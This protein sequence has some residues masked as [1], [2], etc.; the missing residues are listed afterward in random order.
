MQHKLQI[1]NKHKEK[2]FFTAEQQQLAEKLIKLYQTHLFADWDPPGTNDNAKKRFLQRLS[3]TDKAYP[4]GLQQY[5]A[6]ARTQLK[7]IRSNTN[8]YTGYIPTDPQTYNLKEFN[9]S[10]QEY[11]AIGLKNCSAMGVVLVA[12][13]LGERLGYQGLKI[14]IPVEILENTT[15]MELYCSFI[16]ALQNRCGH[17]CRIPFIIMTSDDTNEATVKLLKDS[18]YYGLVKEQFIILK[19]EPVPALADNEA[20]LALKAKYELALKPHGHGDIHMLMHKHNIAGK[21]AAQNINHL[22][23]IQDTNAQA[24]KAALTACGVSVKH[25]LTFNSI[26][27]P[28]I[29][30]EAA[31]ALACLQKKDESKS[32]TINIE[33][34]QL[35]ALLRQT[36][37]A[38]GDVAGEDGFSRFP[39]NINILVINL[40]DYTRILKQTRGIIAEFIN[41]KYADNEKTTFKKPARLET[42][43]Q[44]LPKLFSHNE[45]TG[46]TVF[47]R[48]WCFSANKNNLTDA[49]QKY[50]AGKPPESGASAESDFYLANRMQARFAGMQV[51]KG[52][53]KLIY[54]IPF[55]NGPRIFLSPDF[56]LTLAEVKQKIKGGSLSDQAVLILMGRDIYLE[57][58]KLKGNSGLIVKAVPGAK[59]IIKDKKID[60]NGFSMQ[61][62]SEAE[63]NNPDVPAYLKIRGYRFIKK[64]PQIYIFNEP[65]T[66]TV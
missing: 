14:D 53:N 8:P 55:Q 37:D 41:P 17:N 13:G 48:R 30:G 50:Q 15:Y 5:I 49:A 2:G 40:S 34:N 3:E 29:P 32:I 65:G 43:M 33:Y 56:A 26:A 6:N 36:V 59:V 21:L 25:N 35:D 57:N 44:D 18:N 24:L 66:Y 31:G 20:N 19:Q 7:K 64:N 47:N 60:N 58:I 39:G 27:V 4:G 9:S 61:I 51:S 11:E 10:Y 22:L 38:R 16:K 54:G 23:F 1:F 46:V 63:M 62:L 52:E 28:R 12:G 45:K 42:M